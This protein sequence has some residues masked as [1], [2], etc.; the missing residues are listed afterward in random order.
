MFT[1]RCLVDNNTLDAASYKTEFG[2]SF[3]IQTTAGRIL[4]D[5]GL[6]GSVLVHNAVRMGI[7]LR[8]MNALILSHAHYDH[9][10]GLQAF[11]QYSQPGLPL[12]THPDIF[13]P[14]FSIK[15]GRTRSIGMPLTQKDLSKYFNLHMS[16][17]ALEV[18]PHTWTTGEI[19]P[20]KEFLGSSPTCF[21]QREDGWQPDPYRDDMSLVL[22]GESGLVVV[23]GC[24]H[25]GL[26]NTLAQVQR[27]FN[28]EIT[29]IVGG[30][31]LAYVEERTLQ[32]AIE[33]I[34]TSF[35]GNVPDLFLNH[36]TGEHAIET[37]KQAFGGKVRPC[38]AGT[39]LVFD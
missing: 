3:T 26:L 20:R 25:A 16:A 34:R 27:M 10:G 9:T 6:S 24:C 15:E 22:E 12:Y 8:E 28:R 4:F 29:A 1:L 36:C 37:L 23:C 39:V 7:D 11:M 13:R 2:V 35:E 18:L 31:H 21:I 17:K 32:H 33:V 5:T 30:A 19:T 38:P 14:R